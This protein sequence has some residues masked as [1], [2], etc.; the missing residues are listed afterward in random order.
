MKFKIQILTT[1]I[2]LMLIFSSIKTNETIVHIIENEFNLISI[3][4]PI[5]TIADKI[6]NNDYKIIGIFGPSGGGKTTT[7]HT[8]LNI[9]GHH[10]AVLIS[11]DDYWCYTRAEMKEKN[12]TGYDWQARDKNRFLNDLASLKQGISIDKPVQDYVYERPA[13]H[14][15]RVDAKEIIIL[16]ATL[17]FSEIADLLIFVYAPDEIIFQRRLERDRSKSSF[18]SID[19]LATYLREKSIPA[20][21]KNLLP[22]ATTAD[23]IYDTH[24]NKLYK[25]Q[26]WKQLK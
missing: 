10:K 3:Q 17:D 15:E 8:L 11:V 18:H 23:F 6:I 24:E 26:E 12:L 13:Q 14:T 4:Q 5:H 25:K 22:L 19:E 9:L 20:Y 2:Y 1:T 7:A 21:K 16:E